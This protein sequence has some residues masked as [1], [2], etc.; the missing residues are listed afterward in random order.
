[1]DIFFRQFW[2]DKRLAFEGSSELVV[3]ADILK[4][5][6]VPDTFIGNLWI[7]NWTAIQNEK[8]LFDE[9]IYQWVE[10]LKK[11]KEKFF[12]LKFILILF[13]ELNN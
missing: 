7:L 12:K 8:I 10:Q 9:N 2:V 1:M 3:S 4:E 5:L 6:W 13:I 11:K